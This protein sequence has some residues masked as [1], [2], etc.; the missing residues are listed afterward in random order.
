MSITYGE[1]VGWAT[2]L[3]FWT[4]DLG[5][6][7]VD[8]SVS[9]GG[10]VTD[11]IAVSADMIANGLGVGITQ[12]HVIGIANAVQGVSADPA[13][14]GMAI[15]NGTM[16][17]TVAAPGQTQLHSLVAVGASMIHNADRAVQ[18]VVLQSV[19]ATMGHEVAAPTQQQ[20]FP[21]TSVAA[22]M[23]I[24]TGKRNEIVNNNVLP[25]SG[26][27]SNVSAATNVTAAPFGG[28]TADK[29]VEDTATGDHWVNAEVSGVPVNGRFVWSVYAKDGGR[30]TFWL[31]IQDRD[32]AFPIGQFNLTTGTAS[33]LSNGMVASSQAIGNGWYRCWIASTAGA[34]TGAV[35]P[36]AQLTVDGSG[37]Y[38]GDGTS[39]VFLWGAQFENVTQTVST[40]SKLIETTA[41]PQWVPPELVQSH[42]LVPVN[43]TQG[44]VAGG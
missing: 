23:G 8:I 30:S 7:G 35:F 15:V 3:A 4:N 17:H 28:V 44:N 26:N 25:W 27:I 12:R 20:N 34:G 32:F 5:E 37:N 31:T 36:R 43:A 11:L 24:E 38:T 14:F 6:D 40:P 42:V 39:G 33:A 41:A 2:L 18:G 10:T 1:G 16:G 22:T 21:I 19:P 13:V 29:L 9:G